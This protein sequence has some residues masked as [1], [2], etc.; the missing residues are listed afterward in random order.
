M[1]LVDDVLDFLDEGGPIARLLPGYVARPSQLDMAAM[2]ADALSAKASDK[3]PRVVVEAGTGTGKSLAYLVPS[4][5]SGR[6]VVVATGTKALQDQ[7]YEKDLPL[8]QEALSLALSEE[9][10]VA[11]MKGRN[12][13]VC[14]TRFEAFKREPLFAFVDDAKHFATVE[15]WAEKTPT[16]DRAEIP[17]LPDQWSAW[18]DMDAGSETCIGQRC[19]QF[20]DCHV[21][22]MRRRAEAADVI[23]VNHHLL[24]AD[25]RVRVDN[26]PARPD[27]V[28]DSESEEDAETARAFAQVVPEGD[29]LIIDEAHALAEVAT[30]YF[31]VSFAPGPAERLVRDL[32]RLLPQVPKDMQGVVDRRVALVA[33][34]MPELLDALGR[35]GAGEDRQRLT[36]LPA[37]IQDA[38][39]EVGEAL[40][41]T[42]ETLEEVVEREGR[43]TEIGGEA[44]GLLRRA[45]ARAEELAF[46]CGPSLEDQRFVTWVEGRRNGATLQTAPVDVADGLEKT[47]FAR[48]HPV[49]L[50]SATLAIGQDVRPFEKRVGLFDSPDV[51]IQRAVLPS[52]FDYKTH[53][54]LYAPANFP[55]AGSPEWTGAIDEELKFL[56][57]LSKGGALL[58]FTSRRALESCA[59]RMRP[60]MKR[61]GITCMVQGDAPRLELLANLRALDDAGEMGALFATQSFWEGVDLSG[62]ALRLVAIDRLPFRPPTDPVVEA[63]MDLAKGRGMHPFREVSLPEAALSLKQG[64][65]RLIRNANDAGV[66]AILDGRLRSKSYGKTLTASLPPFC[67]IGSRKTL[68]AFWERFVAPTL[69]RVPVENS[70]DA[71]GADP[72]EEEAPPVSA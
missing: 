32:R 1:A 2:V 20:N 45:N 33:D 39:R 66:V 57:E 41:A 34:E 59:E 27:T 52:P 19:P 29:A 10:Q 16:G 21:T 36:A 24:C 72:I 70:A 55:D 51:E 28:A 22:K 71:E 65:G 37:D 67:K 13:Y 11:L 8:V 25:L 46:L 56:L 49:I 53:A 63:R 35:A 17:G 38:A 50:T 12:N 54:A 30:N 48:P 4:V 6:Q 40:L 47:L 3:T 14:L 31:G 23:V 42:A 44:L 61:E 60:W 18:A 26:L 15:R 68:A 5:L 9:R 62:K 58:L 7:L 43:T 69:A 64:V